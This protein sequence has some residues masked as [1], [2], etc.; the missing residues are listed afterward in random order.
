M[1]PVYVLESSSQGSTSRGI[2]RY[3]SLLK[4]SI[5]SLVSISD[6]TSLPAGSRCIEPFLDLIGR[7]CWN[8]FG[9]RIKQ[10]AVIHDVIPLKYPEFFPLG[11]RGFIRAKINTLLV[12]RLPMIV[13]VSHVSRRDISNICGID[14]EKIR[15]IYSYASMSLK[16]SLAEESPI[17]DSLHIQKRSYYIYVGDVNW[18]KNIVTMAKAFLKTSATLVCVGKSFIANE[19]ELTHPWQAELKEFM[20]V[21]EGSKQ[22]ILAGKVS[23]ADLAQLYRHARYNVLLSRDEGFGFSYVEAGILGTPSLL[24]NIPIF[25]EIAQGKGCL[26][27]DPSDVATISKAITAS[28]NDDDQRDRK[29]A[30]AAARASEFSQVAFTEA[31][32]TLIG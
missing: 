14:L 31:W 23:D 16:E 11:I 17:F 19:K 8:I 27:V 29:G 28:Q 5:P 21:V 2:G 26:Y 22:I 4:E 24:T 10:I 32:S 20:G 13:T 1:K 9:T 12:R 6:A 30:E 7:I 25:H 18:N 15:V 3:V